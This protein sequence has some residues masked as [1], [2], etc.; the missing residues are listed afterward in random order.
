MW[1]NLIRIRLK[2]EP[3]G[4]PEGFQA[5]N[6]PILAQ[7]LMHFQ[8]KNRA[9]DRWPDPNQAKIWGSAGD[10]QVGPVPGGLIHK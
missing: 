1:W 7:F 2:F 4:R 9:S 3:P 8:A 6:Q 5:K 10:F